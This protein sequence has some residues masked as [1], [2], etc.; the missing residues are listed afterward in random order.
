MLKSCNLIITNSQYSQILFNN[1][2][3]VLLLSY[4]VL[5]SLSVCLF[6]QLVEE[7][8]QNKEWVGGDRQEKRVGN[9]SGWCLLILGLLFLISELSWTV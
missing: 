8:N 7:T 5:L 3:V 9:Q 1:V 4:R 6:Y 2:A